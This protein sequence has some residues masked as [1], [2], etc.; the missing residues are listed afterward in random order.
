[1]KKLSLVWDCLWPSGQP[2]LQFR[3]FLCVGTLVG[4]R[5]VNV[6]VLL[7]QLLLELSD[8]PLHLVLELLVYLL[9]LLAE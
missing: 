4:T 8:A 5:I 3:V 9:D 7:A 6:L 1:M 2:G